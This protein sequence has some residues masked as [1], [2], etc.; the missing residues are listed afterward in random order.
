VLAHQFGVEAGLQL[1]LRYNV[2]PNTQ[3]P[4]IRQVGGKR[5]LAMMKWGLVPAWSPEPK[6]KYST[7]NVRSE[8]AATKSTYRSAMK[9]RHCLIPADGFYEWEE[10]NKKKYPHYFQLRHQPIF[11]FAGLWERWDKGQPPLESCTILTTRPNELLQKIEHD[12]MPVILSPNDYAAWLDPTNNA[13]ESLRY[14]FEP[15]PASEM[16]ERPANTYVNKV[17]NEGPE[18]L[19]IAP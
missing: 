5:E 11:A 1:P 10:I 7:F 15:W 14:L 18:C 4:V 9:I 19:T 13:P 6:V 12:R 2:G 3:I 8:E 17:G 16:T